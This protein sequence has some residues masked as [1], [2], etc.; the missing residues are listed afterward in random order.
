M[1]TKELETLLPI[2]WL[3]NKEMFYA[4][5]EEVSCHIDSSDENATTY[6][7]F[8]LPGPKRHGF[9]FLKNHVSVV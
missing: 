5:W 9:F 3:E 2:Q 6:L 7:L 1:F 8:L 4:Q